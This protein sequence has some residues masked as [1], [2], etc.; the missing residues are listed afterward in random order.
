MTCSLHVN[1]VLIHIRM[2]VCVYITS[3]WISL[4]VTLHVNRSLS[5][6]VCVC[7]FVGFFCPITASKCL[8]LCYF[9]LHN[10]NIIVFRSIYSFFA[11]QF[12]C[13]VTGR[14]IFFS[15]FSFNLFLRFLLLFRF[16][17]IFFPAVSLAFVVAHFFFS[18]HFSR[19]SFVLLRFCFVEI[20]ITLTPNFSKKSKYKV[21]ALQ[22]H[23]PR[24]R[25]QFGFVT[26]ANS[27]LLITILLCLFFC[28]I[29]TEK[30][31]FLHRKTIIINNK[32]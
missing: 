8:S 14:L 28:Y 15:V 22:T 16:H 1:N 27:K 26:K 25:E 5:L 9:G 4:C 23:T 19:C 17:L 31:R 2:C 6:R 7:V 3:V 32:N 11:V 30:L 20:L 13:A 12:S 29:F 10:I 18:T 21:H 24:A